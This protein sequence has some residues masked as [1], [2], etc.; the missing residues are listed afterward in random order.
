[1]T[2]TTLVTL[3]YP[4]VFLDDLKK[5]KPWSITQIL[6]SG[7]T[8]SVTTDN[9]ET[10]TQI[11]NLLLNNDNNF[12][13]IVEVERL[14]MKLK[15]IAREYKYDKPLPRS[16]TL[17][18]FKICGH[19]L[20][21]FH[22]NVLELKFDELDETVYYGLWS[23]KEHHHISE[24]NEFW[25]NFRN[26][27]RIELMSPKKPR[28]TA[29]SPWPKGI[30]YEALKR[31]SFRCEY[32]GATKIEIQLHLDHIIPVSKGGTDE[33]DNI[34]VLCGECNLNKSNLI[35]KNRDENI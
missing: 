25:I 14:D 30:R 11:N 29:R 15:D 13:N 5:N 10:I 22:H 28:Q 1:M 26:K 2:E 20:G 35:H 4:T 34:R 32:C 7:I 6:E 9:E 16:L 33:L 27:L 12:V 19:V 24:I 3:E 17:G 21:Q 31:A 18:L 8:F 23:T